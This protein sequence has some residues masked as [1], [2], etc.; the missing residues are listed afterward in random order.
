MN[1]P[2]T[3]LTP[4]NSS[5]AGTGAPPLPP[6]IEADAGPTTALEALLK[7]PAHLISALHTARST[8]MAVTLF[9]TA[10]AVLM[11]YGIIVGSF[12][13]GLQLVAAPLKISLGAIASILICLPSF[14]I[15]ASLAGADVT[16]R[17]ALGMLG[18]TLALA[19]VLLIGF[20]PVAWVFAQSTDSVALIGTLHLLFWLIA[21]AFGL[22]MLRVFMNVA[23][24][25]DRLHLKVWAA[26]FVLVTLQMTTSL[27]PIVGTAPT[28]I[29]TEKKF[30]LQHWT[31]TL[32]DDAEY[33][34]PKRK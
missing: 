26:I 7:R 24:V 14:F 27:R 28:I 18:A 29:P 6:I 9:A 23:K 10:F 17:G 34:R 5:A 16:L 15:F 4:A 12:S 11:L 19:A 20:A 8:R 22:R 32:S 2:N 30:F 21:V 31:E 1:E 3:P 33:D 25:G 13:G